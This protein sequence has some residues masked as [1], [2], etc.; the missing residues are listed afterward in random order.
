MINL[1]KEQVEKNP[2]SVV[3]M[4]R[5]DEVT[6]GELNS[7]ANQMTHYLRS[8]GVKEET[9]VG[10]SLERSFELIVG[11]LEILKAGG[12]MCR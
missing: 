1:F 10:I 9:L 2:N 12:H 4:F 11:I 8:L 5:E 6:H 7:R 3:V